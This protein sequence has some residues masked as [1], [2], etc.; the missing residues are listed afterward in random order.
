MPR[1]RCMRSSGRRVVPA[2]KVMTGMTVAPN[3]HNL[4]QLSA[5]ICRLRLNIPL[6]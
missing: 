1:S 5:S 6:V 3:V 4:I 2:K